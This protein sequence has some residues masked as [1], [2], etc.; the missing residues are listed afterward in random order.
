MTKE[1]EIQYIK[2][3]SSESII[4]FCSE[5]AEGEVYILHHPYKFTPIK[6][7]LIGTITGSQLIPWSECS[8]DGPIVLESRNVLIKID[9][10]DEDKMEYRKLVYK[11]KESPTSKYMDASD[12]ANDNDKTN[13]KVAS[14]S[15]D[16]ESKRSKAPLSLVYDEDELEDLE[17]DEEEDVVVSLVPDEDP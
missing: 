12:M 10:S 15:P 9:P 3:T 14:D 17:D 5:L 11:A 2:L 7:P 4:T 13:L 1:V 8:N 6:N 16:V